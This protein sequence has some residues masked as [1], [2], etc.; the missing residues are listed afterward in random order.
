YADDA[1]WRYLGHALLALIGVPIYAVIA[2]TLGVFASDPMAQEQ[3]ARIR[4]KYLYLFTLLSGFYGYGIWAAVWWQSLEIVL[5][6]ALLAFAL[7]QKAADQLPYLLDPAAAPPARVSASDGLIAAMMFLVFQ[8]VIAVIWRT[9]QPGL[10]GAAL[11]AS[12]VGSGALI[13]YGLVRWVYWRSKTEQIPTVLR[14]AP[15]SS[16]QIGA[17][18]GMLAASIGLVYLWLA[19]HFGAL[20]ETS[21]SP[22]D[23]PTLQYWLVALAILAAPIFEEFIF[24]GLIFGGLRRS[25][26]LVPAAVAS[27]AVF[28]V[29]HPPASI[30]PVFFLGLCTALAYERSRVLAA[31]MLT[32]AVYN[33]V[34]L[35]YQFL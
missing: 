9:V 18:A 16:W 23:D 35:G 31:P 26:G 33:A 25:M 10:G 11:L 22:F 28:A 15:R 7:W 8:I 21:A 5:L 12:F 30:I 14:G 4:P 24:R 1:G 29:V 6:A 17:S 20:S 27:A 13:T 3:G 34:V 32:H 2:V 19:Q